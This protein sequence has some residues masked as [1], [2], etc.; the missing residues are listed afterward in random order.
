MLELIIW[1]HLGFHQKPVALLNINGFYE[2][3][4]GAVGLLRGKF[5]R[6]SWVSHF[7]SLEPA[8]APPNSPAKSYRTETSHCIVLTVPCCVSCIDCRKGFFDHC[9]T[10]VMQESLLL[11]CMRRTCAGARFGVLKIDVAS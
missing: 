10:E 7:I 3:L 8:M 9:V 5:A 11:E 1:L 2:H 4:L 6:D